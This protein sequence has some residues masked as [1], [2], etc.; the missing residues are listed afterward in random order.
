MLE[1]TTSMELEDVLNVTYH[2]QLAAAL[3]QVELK[4]R[5]KEMAAE[6]AAHAR[7]LGRI[8]RGL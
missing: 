8:V 6:E 2:T 4:L 5:L 7:E 1:W 3:G